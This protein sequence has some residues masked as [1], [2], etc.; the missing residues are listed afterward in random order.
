MSFSSYPSDIVRL[1]KIS[2][3]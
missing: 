2:F 3:G 1:S